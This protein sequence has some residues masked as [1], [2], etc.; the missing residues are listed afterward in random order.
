MKRRYR[1]YEVEIVWVIWIPIVTCPSFAY[2]SIMD[3]N[4]NPKPYKQRTYRKFV[5]LY[6]T[7]DSWQIQSNDVLTLS[8]SCTPVSATAAP[9]VPSGA[10]LMHAATSNPRH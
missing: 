6:N 7:E 2:K 9:N 10:R 8:R 5:E 4:S 3:L 1:I